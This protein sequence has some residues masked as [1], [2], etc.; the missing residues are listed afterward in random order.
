[1]TDSVI[2]NF[3]GPAWQHLERPLSPAFGGLTEV[4]NRHRTEPYEWQNFKECQFSD[5]TSRYTNNKALRGKEGTL[6]LQRA[7]LKRQTQILL[8][9]LG[10]QKCPCSFAGR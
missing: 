8:N 4:R 10:L 5:S 2:R 6:I 9:L 7:S 1:M 3:R